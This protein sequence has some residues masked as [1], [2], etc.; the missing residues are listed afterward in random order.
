[1][2][3]TQTSEFRP[4]THENIE[5]NATKGDYPPNILLY[6]LFERQAAETPEATAVVYEDQ[7]LSCR[8][9]GQAADALAWRLQAAG[10]GRRKT[11]NASFPISGGISTSFP[12][13]IIQAIVRRT[14]QKQ[15][16]EA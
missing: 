15:K 2:F 13:T 11:R 14:E 1:M 5:R 9:L 3:T 4:L 6:R 12:T 7:T 10:V 16:V 8:Q